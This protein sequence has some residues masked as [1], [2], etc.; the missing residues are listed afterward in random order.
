[1][2]NN[3]F[4]KELAMALHRPAVFRMPHLAATLAF[5][6][7]ADALLFSSA[8]VVPAK[9]QASGFTWQYPTLRSWFSDRLSSNR[10]R[11]AS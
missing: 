3:E 6:E 5:G 1:V 7:M 2:T 11:I 9:M 8:R 10:T 4:T